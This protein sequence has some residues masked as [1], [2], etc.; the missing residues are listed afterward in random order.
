MRTGKGAS[1]PFDALEEADAPPMARFS[2]I[3][4]SLPDAPTPMSSSIEVSVAAVET[5]SARIIIR[6]ASAAVDAMSCA[7]APFV[8]AVADAVAAAD[9][10][11]GVAI[12][13]IFASGKNQGTFASP[14]IA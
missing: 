11:N 7:H 14:R 10:K 8:W 2:M 5:L 13:R 4:V 3:G 6:P 12:G 1:N 9:P